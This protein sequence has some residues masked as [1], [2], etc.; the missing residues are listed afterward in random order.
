[1]GEDTSSA[2]HLSKSGQNTTACPFV[3]LCTADKAWSFSK[4]LFPKTSLG[5][6]QCPNKEKTKREKPPSKF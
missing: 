2:E 4:E 6:K 1:V 5:E 3:S